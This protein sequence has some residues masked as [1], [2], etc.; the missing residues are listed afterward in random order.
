MALRRQVVAELREQV[1]ELV[2]PPPEERVDQP[3]PRHGR[4]DQP[5][6]EVRRVEVEHPLAEPVRGH[7]G[8]VVRHVWREQ[9]HDRSERVVLPA[10]E[11][12]PD[13]PVVDDQQRPRVVQVHRV[14]VIGEAGVQDLRDPTDGGRPRAHIRTLPHPADCN[15]RWPVLGH[16]LRPGSGTSWVGPRGLRRVGGLGRRRG[17][18]V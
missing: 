8:T 1:V 6:V 5:V 15:R 3:R 7:R 2:D 16:R 14:D 4:T 17:H 9:G 12:V 10:V 11:V 18:P 13:G